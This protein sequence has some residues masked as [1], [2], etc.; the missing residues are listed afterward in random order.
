GSMC[1]NLRFPDYYG[2]VSFTAPSV[3]WRVQSGTCNGM[4]C[5]VGPTLVSNNHVIAHSDQG[6]IGDIIATGQVNNMGTLACVIPLRCNTSVDLA[7]ATITDPA[8]TELFSVH[9]IGRLANVRRP[10]M[11]ESIQKYGATTHYTRGSITAFGN[12]HVGGRTIIGVFQ[13]SG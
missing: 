1:K 3:E 9:Q 11:G 10:S 2:T 12:I 8:T 6:Q 5:R 7:L 4:S 13:T